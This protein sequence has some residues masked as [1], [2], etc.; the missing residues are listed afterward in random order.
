M[1]TSYRKFAIGLK[2]G[3]QELM[4][5]RA[6]IRTATAVAGKRTIVST[7]IDFIAKLSFLVSS[8]M[9]FELL[10]SLVFTFPSFRAMK[11]KSCGVVS[12]GRLLK[13]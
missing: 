7:A 5:G 11:L 2:S 4:K 6:E 1:G 3:E 8:A 10:A 9:S 13:S 12:E